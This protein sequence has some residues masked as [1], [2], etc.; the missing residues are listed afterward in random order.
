MPDIDELRETTD[1]ADK[2]SN[3]RKQYNKLSAA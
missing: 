1:L 2:L 3:L